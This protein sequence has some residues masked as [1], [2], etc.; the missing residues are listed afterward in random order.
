MAMKLSRSSS[1]IDG[2]TLL[3]RD[4]AYGI[5]S[6]VHAMIGITPNILLAKVHDE[7]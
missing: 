6:S 7:D 3:T 4:S 5:S 1:V 2:K